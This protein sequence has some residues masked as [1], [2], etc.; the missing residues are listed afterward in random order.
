[1]LFTFFVVGGCLLEISCVQEREF[2]VT[3]F[4]PIGINQIL[5]GYQSVAICVLW[6]FIFCFLIWALNQ[7][8]DEVNPF[9]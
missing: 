6:V 9:D 5:M 4:L 2:M 3:D 7:K 1:M 8:I